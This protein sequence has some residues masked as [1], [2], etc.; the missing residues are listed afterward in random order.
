MGYVIEKNFSKCPKAYCIPFHHEPVH[1]RHKLV[2]IKLEIN[3]NAA[4]HVFVQKFLEDPPDPSLS[5]VLSVRGCLTHP[6]LSLSRHCRCFVMMSPSFPL[7]VDAGT[8][9]PQPD[10]PDTPVSPYLSSPDE[11]TATWGWWAEPGE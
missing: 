4:D 11:V 1:K 5:V 9:S 3:Q 6:L 7:K 8:L 10:T 2:P